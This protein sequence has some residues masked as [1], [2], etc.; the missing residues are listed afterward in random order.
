MQTMARKAKP[1]QR[2]DQ[3]F[4]RRTITLPPDL[5]QKLQAMATQ[6]DRPVSNLIAR[7]CREWFAM[8]EAKAKK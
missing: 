7:I 5:D 8:Q 3:E 4:E 1:R 2:T 6:E